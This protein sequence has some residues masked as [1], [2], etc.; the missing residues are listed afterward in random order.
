MIERPNFLY[1]M[2]D[3]QR[4]DHLSCAGNPLLRTP[5]I[6]SIAARGT[7]FDRFYVAS[8]ICMP[9]RATIMTGRMPSLHGVRMNG[10]PLGLDA[11]CFTHLLKRAGYRT[12]LMGKAH[13]QN[14]TGQEK[15]FA[16][17]WPEGLK[18]PPPDLSE[19][20]RDLRK[21]PAYDRELRADECDDPA[22]DE[23]EGDFYGFDSFRLCT[24]HGD[25][26]RGHY[27]RWL[28]RRL[29]DS[30]SYRSR[31]NPLPDP[32]YDAPQCRRTRIPEALYPSSY[33]ADMTV[34]Y[35]EK[36]A[37]EGARAPFFVQCSFPDPHHPFTPPGRYWDLY[38][39]ADIA[40]PESFYHRPH[41]QTPA[42][43]AM[44]REFETGV[45]DR[46]WVLPYA[47]N[48]A[49]AKQ[50]VAV[51]YGMIALIDDCIG[52]VL[53][54]LEEFGLA[55]N[56]VVV[57]TSDHGDWMGDHGIVQK[58]PLHYQS[59][60]RVP[61]LW[62]DPAARDRPVSTDALCSSLDIARSILARAGFA[63]FNGM[64]GQD[65]AAVLAGGESEHDCLV[66]EQQTAR[67][68]MGLTSSVRVRT[69]QDRRWRMS[70]WEGQDFGELYDLDNDP[71]EI[72][73]LWDDAGHLAVRK[74]LMERMAWKL[75]ELQDR[76]PLQTGEA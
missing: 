18:A 30:D 35:L 52:R 57:F 13:L 21:G 3:Q 53:A 72:A 45:A 33:I 50:I 14:F 65:L 28:E 10:I 48:E 5:H 17:E 37:A 58:G 54:A 55:A 51:T 73:N 7:R 66:I 36:H 74:D 4:A 63:P 19:A 24:W 67:P 40:L 16:T 62:S 9:N 20:D 49:E 76:S 39:P 42:L 25:S 41:D 70:L 12:A 43:A 32:R 59:L 22:T 71:G 15:A 47:V 75:F 8:P 26:V 61:F 27:S 23:A 1:F 69:F 68:Y 64:Q 60:I 11:T 46:R 6:D 44:H 2:T 34:D 29:P 56:T 31:E 38:D